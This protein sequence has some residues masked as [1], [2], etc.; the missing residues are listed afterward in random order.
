VIRRNLHFL[1]AA[2]LLVGMTAC[3][4][5]PGSE[6]LEPVARAPSYTQKV[7]ML[8][9]TTRERGSPE[10]PN[11]FTA[12][13]AKSLNYAALTISVPT[14]HKAGQIEWPDQTPPD[15]SMHFITTDRQFLS[16]SEFLSE[17]RQ[18]AREGGSE[19]GAVLVFVHGYNTLY[20]EAVYRFAQIVHDSGFS[21]T[22]ILFAW[23]S[24]GKAPLYLADRDASTYSRDYLEQALLELSSVREVHGINILAHSMGN[25]LAVETLRQAKMNGHGNFN[26]KLGEVIL[27][28]PDLDINVFRTQL[29]VIGPL[30]HPMTIFVSGDDKALALSTALAGGVERAGMVT[31]TDARAVAAAERYNL[32]IIDLTAVDDG[33]GNHHSK[34]AQSGAVVAAIGRGLAS[35]KNDVSAQSGVVSAVTDVGT[36]LIKVPTAI[37]GGGAQ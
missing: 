36:S 10:D 37:L 23:P 7:R 33:S 18:R 32:N 27:A 21:G 35:E 29:E 1:T 31:A 20:E 8:V 28:S 5:R 22:A 16:G 26:G 13:R 17:V 9:A 25:W 19:A 24:R 6:I 30:A 14:H 12:R 4:P 2:I 11:A 34:F 15:P 3:A